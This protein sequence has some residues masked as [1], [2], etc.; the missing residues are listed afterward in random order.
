MAKTTLHSVRKELSELITNITEVLTSG[1]LKDIGDYR[2]NCG[3]LNGLATAARL[4][5]EYQ[6]A[7][8]QHD[9]D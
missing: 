9:A 2:Y 8:E 5:G 4:L 6:T 1:D 7:L 3:R